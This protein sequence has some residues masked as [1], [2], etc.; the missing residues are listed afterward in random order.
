MANRYYIG[1]AGGA[2]NNNANWDAVSG[3]PGPASFPVAGDNAFL[4]AASPGGPT[5]TAAAACDQLDCTG[6]VGTLNLGGFDLTIA[7]TLFKLVA[8]MTFIEGGATPALDFTAVAGTVQITSAGKD[9]GS[10]RCGNVGAGA[11]YQLQD[12]LALA[13]DLDLVRGTFQFNNQNA[14]IGRDLYCR[15]TML[16]N[17]CDLGSGTIEVR[18]D[19]EFRVLNVVSAGTSTFRMPGTGALRIYGNTGQTFYNLYLADNTKT[20]TFSQNAAAFG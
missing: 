18:R 13:R 6:F 11:T 9:L 16:A 2:W 15:A 20:I 19:A 10:I 12:A 3:G 17:G 4:D 1:P 7:T 14:V 8:G 5:L